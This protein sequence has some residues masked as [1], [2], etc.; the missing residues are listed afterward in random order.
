M[1]DSIKKAVRF[2]LILLPVAAL[3]GLFTGMYT[4]EAYTD[5]VRQ[6]IL[7]QVESYSKFLLTTTLQSALYA[8]VCGFL[9]HLVAQKT[10][11][12]RKPS[13]EKSKL[14]PA[15]AATLVCGVLFSLDY[16][17]F[18]KWIPQLAETYSS[19]IT[20]ANFLS[21]V[22]YGGVIEEVLMRLFL[23][24]LFAFLGWKLFFRK[25]DRVHIPEGVFVAANILTAMLFAAGHL[26]ATVSL[27]GGLT[28]LIVFR[29]FL[30]NGGLGLV[31]GRLYR[32]YGIQY[33][34]LCHAGCHIISKVIWIM[35]I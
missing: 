1:K 7:A 30:L 23:M 5:D 9:G 26:P 25:N 21:S 29:C 12:M 11:L 19:L 16:W 34:M 35:F 15:F 20:F 3:A 8:T 14:F 28:P 10:G 17:T 33:A 24:S 4:F 27:F 18:A 32:K 31:F 6:Q 13:F 22:L 2:T